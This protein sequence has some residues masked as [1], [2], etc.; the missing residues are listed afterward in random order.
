MKKIINYDEISSKISLISC[1]II[2][3]PKS[4][5]AS[6]LNFITKSFNHISRLNKINII[7]RNAYLNNIS[8]SFVTCLTSLQTTLGQISVLQISQICIF[9]ISINFEDYIQHILET[10]MCIE[11]C[12]IYFCLICITHTE[13]YNKNFIDINLNK[14]KKIINLT[15]KYKFIFINPIFGHNM[16]NFNSIVNYYSKQYWLDNPVINNIKPYF[17]IIRSYDFTSNKIIKNN[18]HFTGG[19]VGG[20]IKNGFIKN[21]SIVHIKPGLISKDNKKIF[22][23]KSKI[24][25]IQFDQSSINYCLPKGIN[26]IELSIDPYFTSDNKLRGHI[27]GPI[28]SLPPVYSKLG[29]KF[30]GLKKIFLNTSTQKEIIMK[31][32]AIKEDIILCINSIFIHGSITKCINNNSF[33]IKLLT[34]K[35]IDLHN[36]AIVFRKINYNWMVS[37]FANNIIG[38]PIITNNELPLFSNFISNDSIFLVFSRKNILNHFDS[39]VPKI[40][41]NINPFQIL[42]TMIN[43][44][45]RLTYKFNYS[46][47]IY[48]YSK[49]KFKL[50]QLESALKLLNILY[51]K[52]R[53]V[54]QNFPNLNDSVDYQQLSVDKQSLSINNQRLFVELNITQEEYN[55]YYFKK[56]KNIFK[57]SKCFSFTFMFYKKSS[58]LVQICTHC[59]FYFIH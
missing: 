18:N 44:K 12:K 56:I 9:V 10:L 31:S 40:I 54:E 11:C 29:F 30:N 59:G 14:L 23:I 26:G 8:H 16:N 19:V 7:Y 39:F 37:G 33:I 41:K 15:C 36:N 17:T 6:L 43:K 1:S 4:G 13:L 20:Y 38:D 51:T 58:L 2:G 24:K 3:H 28:S 47:K 34:P 50:N 32:L 42:S 48:Q 52:D 53:Y 46:L 22:S 27:L 21:N 57:C 45:I 49:F 5:K 35:C 55:N 25:N